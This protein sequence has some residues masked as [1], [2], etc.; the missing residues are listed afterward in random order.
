[1]HA[2]RS[3]GSAL[4]STPTIGYPDQDAG[5]VS[6]IRSGVRLPTSE[7]G[8]RYSVAQFERVKDEISGTEKIYL[9]Y[10]L[11]GLY[12]R[13]PFSGRA[14]T[15]KEEENIA[16]LI[17]QLIEHSQYHALNEL[18]QECDPLYYLN[19]QPASFPDN[20]LSQFLQVVSESQANLCQLM[21]VVPVS[22]RFATTFSDKAETISNFILRSPQ[23]EKF[24]IVG[25]DDRFSPKLLEAIAQVG[26]AKSIDFYCRDNVSDALAEALSQMISRCNKLRSVCLQE[27]HFSDNK[28]AEIFHALGNCPH[29]NDLSVRKWQL[30]GKETWQELQRLIQHSKT[31]ESFK[32]TDWFSNTYAGADT[33]HEDRLNAFS[34]S[35]AANRSLKFLSLGPLPQHRANDHITKL[36]Q[37]LQTQATIQSLEFDSFDFIDTLAENIVDGL[38][39]LADLV[40]KNQRIIDIKG[41][42]T[43]QVDQP[44]EKYHLLSTIDQRCATAAKLLKDRLARNSA[45]ASGNLARIFSQAFFPS[46]GA[47]VGGNHIGDPGL[48]LTEHLLRLSPN[49]ASFGKA[50]VEIA[51][52][53]DET[54]RH[55]QTRGRA[56]EPPRLPDSS[57]T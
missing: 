35:I 44:V 38:E 28:S 42:D 48:Y 22:T 15:R 34:L 2:S 36:F 20:L 13:G 37:A 4:T 39:S 57:S 10:M 43:S 32:C 47:P 7:V 55:E 26:N 19:I 31:L 30:G 51:L 5:H 46:P 49:L 14:E 25:V 54:A 41:L 56:T 12:P 27:L 18:L 6:P 29:L 1:M 3:S 53:V 23:L 17:S 24:K 45:I 33:N 9:E 52:T 50:M 21:F 40:E 16:C 11:H 8:L